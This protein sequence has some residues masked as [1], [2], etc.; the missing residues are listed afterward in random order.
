MLE[1]L[2]SLA[3]EYLSISLGVRLAIGG[4]LGA[5]G[6]STV[7]GFIA[8]YGAVNYTLAYGARLPTEGV[9]YLRYAVTGISLVMFFIAAAVLLF[10]NWLLRGSIQQ[11]L[12]S[13][14]FG[15]GESFTNMPLKMYLIKAVLPAIGATQGLMQMVYV[16]APLQRISQWVLISLSLALAVVI[17]TLGRKP[18]WTKWFVIGIFV[19]CMSVFLV[20]SF[21]PSLYG[22]ALLFARQGGGLPVKLYINC[23]D[24]APCVPEV[25]GQLFL[26][27]TDYFFL[28][29]PSSQQLKEIPSRSVEG[30]SY[31]GEERWG[32]K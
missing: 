9:P 28:R 2:R 31:T 3:S 29:D 8:E 12:V 15:K 6:S 30:I 22:K 1:K 19:I 24:V 20:A 25:S 11:F 27:T 5:I 13:N 26:R 32:T 16:F 17:M 10:F 7:I 21:T 23:K 18:H 14:F 4:I